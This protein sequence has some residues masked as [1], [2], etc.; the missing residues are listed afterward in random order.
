M[1][2]MDVEQIES[3]VSKTHPIIPVFASRHQPQNG[4]E[5]KFSIGYCMAAALTKG[6]VALEDFTDDKVKDPVLQAIAAKCSYIHPA[7]WGVGTVDPKVEV[8]ITLNNGRTFT[9]LVLLPKGEPENPLTDNELRDKFRNCAGRVFR[10]EQVERLYDT[11]LHMER[12]NDVNDLV[13]ITAL[14]HNHPLS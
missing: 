1:P 14:N 3:I 2:G 6:Q 9:S 10:D 11:V 5:G 8:T 12:V 4:Y 13:D 7:G